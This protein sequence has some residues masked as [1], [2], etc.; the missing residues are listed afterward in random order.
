MNYVI[1]RQDSNS[2]G[3]YSNDRDTTKVNTGDTVVLVSKSRRKVYVA[4]KDEGT[5]RDCEKCVFDRGR[6][7]YYYPF[8]CQGIIL[9]PV[10]EVLEDL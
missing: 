3:A 10:A 8:I 7:C 1:Y 9:R 5:E 6:A 4:I 2:V